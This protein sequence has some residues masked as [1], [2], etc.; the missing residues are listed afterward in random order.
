MVAVDLDGTLLQPDHSVSERTASAL[1]RTQRA[2]VTVAI[3]TGRPPRWV[4]DPARQAGLLGPAVCANGA[5][6][7]DVVKSEILD[8][9]PIEPRV[10]HDLVVAL[11]A[12]VPSIRFAFEIGLDFAR[13]PDYELLWSA[14]VQDAVEDDALAIVR[15]PVTKLLAR[16]S[17]LS[18]AELLPLAE[19]ASGGRVMATYS[20]PSLLE[21]SRAGVTKAH[22]VERLCATLGISRREVLAFGD[23]P[24]DLPLLEWAGWGVAV[25]N[26]HADVL[27]R[28]DEITDANT[29]DGVAAV[30]ERLLTRRGG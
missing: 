19:K 15:Q 21:M 14:M 13:E 16:D 25:G 12:A 20:S 7:Y 10:A 18:A 27:R 22:G 24:N 26:S 5:L 8:H 6:T 1:R 11:R 28:A 17:R 4:H 29:D 23:M 2:G 30:L 3:V 9:L